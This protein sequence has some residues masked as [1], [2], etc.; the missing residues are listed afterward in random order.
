MNQFVFEVENLGQF[1]RVIECLK[2]LDEEL[3]VKEQKEINPFESNMLVKVQVDAN[4]ETVL[5]TLTE[6]KN[7]RLPLETIRPIQ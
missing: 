2:S 4:Y 6:V 5:K 1:N 7:S 3:Q